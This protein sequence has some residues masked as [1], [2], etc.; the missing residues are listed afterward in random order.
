E[1]LGDA[2][3]QLCT[4]LALYAR[5]PDADEGLLTRK[6]IA[7]VREETL[8]EAAMRWNLGAYIQMDY[9]E[10]HTGGRTKPSILADA[11][12]AVFAAV[13]LDG[14]F[15]AAQAVAA[16]ALNDY[17][18][19]PAKDRTDWKSALQEA[20]QAKQKPS[21]SYAILEE[22]GPPHA[23][24]FTACVQCE[25]RVLGMGKGKSKKDAEQQAAREACKQWQQEQ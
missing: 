2:V 25:E 1:F 19:P 21:P 23:R 9:G 14:G 10:N 3:L 11:M 6:R 24:I 20:L 7:L 4:S 18:D 17:E 16:H 12:E 5:M 15:A 13:Y 22:A 8:A